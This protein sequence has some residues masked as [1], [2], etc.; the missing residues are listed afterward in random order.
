MPDATDPRPSR[1]GLRL[2]GDSVKTS[3]RSEAEEADAPLLRAFLAGDERAFG[4]LV[5]RHQSTV[6]AL[7]RRY[8]PDPDDARDLAQRAF[9]KAFEAARRS[10]WLRARGKVPFRAWLYRIAV[11]LGRNHVR[12]TRRWQRAPVT[13]ADALPVQAPG[14]AALERTE[15]ERVLRASVLNL[16]RRQREVLTLRIDAELPFREIAEML[17]ITENNAKVH[18]HYAVRRLRE[19]I[20]SGE[21]P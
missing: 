5:R 20:A 16:P 19:V 21:M 2:V 4:E 6:L 15:R 14:T 8:A 12:D 13:A 17:G 3:D 11:N 9:I 10:F 1:P 7:L 18:F